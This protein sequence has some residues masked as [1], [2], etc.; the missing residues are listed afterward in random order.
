MQLFFSGLRYSYN[1]GSLIFNRV[2]KI[3]VMDK[4][5]NYVEL[6]S[7][8]L[9]SIVCGLYTAQLVGLMEDKSYNILSVTPKDA[10]GDAVTDLLTAI[11]RDEK[12]EELKEWLALQSY[13]KSFPAGDNNLPQINFFDKLSERKIK[14]KGFSL[15]NEIKYMNNFALYVYVISLLLSITLLFLLF[16][17]TRKTIRF[18]EK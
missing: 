9:Y 11:I 7:K 4:A 18:L 16:V 3:E 14:E 2:K 10:A 12:G 8:Q 17:I 1:S 13:L 5:G 6:V 15:K